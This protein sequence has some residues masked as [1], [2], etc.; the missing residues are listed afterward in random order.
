[1]AVSEITTPNGKVYIRSGDPD[2]FAVVDPAL[3]VKPVID[4]RFQGGKY[5]VLNKIIIEPA[6]SHPVIGRIDEQNPVRTDLEV[7]LLTLYFGD[8]F[9]G[10]DKYQNDFD[11]YITASGLSGEYDSINIIDF[12]VLTGAKER[13][14]RKPD[15]T[16][17]DIMKLGPADPRPSLS[18]VEDTKEGNQLMIEI[19][20]YRGLK[21]FIPHLYASKAISFE[22]LVEIVEHF[23]PDIAERNKY[24]ASELGPKL[25]QKQAPLFNSSQLQKLKLL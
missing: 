24:Y 23:Y 18:E 3:G 19:I 25:K 13:N 7:F 5:Q 11:S 22:D 20:K 12:M 1:M 17:E 14:Y 2:Y 6:Y 8:F 10:Y 4:I 21:G 9:L 16:V 15:N